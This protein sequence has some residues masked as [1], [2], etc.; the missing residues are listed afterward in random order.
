MH[1][2]KR[3]RV[4][5]SG[6]PKRRTSRRHRSK[7]S[8]AQSDLM[9]FAVAQL[10]FIAGQLSNKAIPD[11]WNKNMVGGA[12]LLVGAAPLLLMKGNNTAKAFGF[13]FAASG[14]GDIA[15]NLGLISGIGEVSND[16]DLAVVLNGGDFID[17]PFDE[18]NGNSD[19]LAGTKNDYAYQQKVL[20]GND[21][22]NV[23]NGEMD[24]GVINGEDIFVEGE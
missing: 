5:V 12:K 7:M 8:G 14:T 1:H 17:I 18:I 10:G 22:L 6:T 15:Q 2:K 20:A 23:I 4:K 13:G 16:D 19:V 21:D 9:D 24:L 3:K 11:I